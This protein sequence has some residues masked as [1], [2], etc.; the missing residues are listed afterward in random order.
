MAESFTVME[1]LL[2]MNLLQQAKGSM[3]MLRAVDKFGQEVA[4]G[5]KEKEVLEFKTEGNS[6]RWNPEA[7]MAVEIECSPLVKVAVQNVLKAMDKDSALDR[8]LM[9][10]WERFVEGKVPTPV[11]ASPDGTP[12]EPVAA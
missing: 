6:I 11:I 8:S 5:T 7:A 10:I 4:F 9:P 1:R 12:K 3:E 2:L